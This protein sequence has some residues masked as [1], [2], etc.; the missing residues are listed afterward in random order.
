MSIKELSDSEINLIAA[1]NDGLDLKDVLGEAAIF[2]CI[3]AATVV[4]L[5][6]FIA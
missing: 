2:L 1:G 3:V 5:I 4:F 6:T